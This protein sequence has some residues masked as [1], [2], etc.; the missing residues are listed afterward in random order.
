MSDIE[1]LYDDAHI[2]MDQATQNLLQ[3][4]LFGKDLA[5]VSDYLNLHLEEE[6]L[7]VAEN[8]RALDAALIEDARL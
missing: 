8:I 1:D 2:Y 3:S 5:Y 7:L 4:L 6:P